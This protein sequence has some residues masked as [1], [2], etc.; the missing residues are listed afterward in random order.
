MLYGYGEEY[1][2]RHSC[3]GYERGD[4]LSRD[5]RY[6]QKGNSGDQIN[7]YGAASQK[8]ERKCRCCQGKCGKIAREDNAS[9]EEGQHREDHGITDDRLEASCGSRQY[10]ST[11]NADACRNGGQR[12]AVGYKR[13]RKGDIHAGERIGKAEQQNI[14]K[15]QGL[16]LAAVLLYIVNGVFFHVLNYP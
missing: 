7:E 5:H 14:E 11:D 13:R 16:A 4:Y 10:Q 1:S 3:H 2:R 6:R 12:N 9:A 15:S 8:Q